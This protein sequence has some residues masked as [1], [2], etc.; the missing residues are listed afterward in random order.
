MSLAMFEFF[1]NGNYIHEN[2]IQLVRDYIASNLTSWPPNRGYWLRQY[3]IVSKLN[4]VCNWRKENSF[5]ALAKKG[6]TICNNELINCFADEK[7]KSCSC[8]KS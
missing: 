8:S 1:E 2:D 7:H 3:H 6:E 4:I 5:C